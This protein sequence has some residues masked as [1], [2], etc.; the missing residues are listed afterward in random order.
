MRHEQRAPSTS[1]AKEGDALE[2]F[3]QRLHGE[4]A[5]ACRL[6]RYAVG[7]R[8]RPRNPHRGSVGQSHH[9]LSAPIC[10]NRE[11]LSLEWMMPAS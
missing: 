7:I 4:D 6:R 1:L 5:L 2:Q 11:G 3:P 10:H 8:P 9:D